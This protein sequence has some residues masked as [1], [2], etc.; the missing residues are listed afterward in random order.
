MT[1]INDNNS[2]LNNINNPNEEIKLIKKKKE[3]Q[4]IKIEID[5]EEKPTSHKSNRSKEKRPKTQSFQKPKGRNRTNTYDGTNP[6]Q[7]IDVKPM[8]QSVIINPSKN[9]SSKHNLQQSES[10]SASESSTNINDKKRKQTKVS[11]ITIGTLQSEVEIDEIASIRSNIN[12]V[13][14]SSSKEQDEKRISRERKDRSTHKSNHEHHHDHQHEIKIEKDEE[15]KDHYRESYNLMLVLCSLN[16]EYI[17]YLVN[18]GTSL[19]QSLCK[20]HKFKIFEYHHRLLNK[21]QREQLKQEIK[22]SEGFR[23]LCNEETLQ[24][25]N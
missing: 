1:F 18:E 3:T 11:D 21:E 24:S 4:Q 9:E 25:L 12:P 13:K 7:K 8:N 5:G 2:D 23:I 15:S 6:T 10:L 22:Q 19:N 17:N 20:K 14:K 16:K